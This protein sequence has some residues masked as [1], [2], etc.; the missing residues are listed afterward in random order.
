MAGRDVGDPDWLA[1]GAHDG[2]HVSARRAVFAG[3]PGVDRFT[4]DA[5][6]GLR[7]A[8]GADQ[9]A[10]EHDVRPAL[11]G[12]LLQGLVQV[13]GLR[14]EHPEGLV[15][16]AVGR[17]AGHPEPGT[18]HRDLALGTH[19]HQHQQ[20]LAEAGQQAGSLT[21][22][23]DAAL[24][25]QQLGQ[26]ADQFTGDIEHGTIRD[27]RGVLGRL[28]LVEENSLPRTPR[29]GPHPHVIGVLGPH[30]ADLVEITSLYP[31]QDS[32]TGNVAKCRRPPG[33]GR[34]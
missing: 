29:P 11:L 13:R 31:H 27:Q 3:I 8:V 25:A 9:L 20:R 16:V 30:P 23:A 21:G 6:G 19:P 32:S 22:A 7:T 26:L 15:A 33:G 12:H 17:R 34:S 18:D 24:G 1:V 2:L 14:G 5:G 28:D 10:V 4:F